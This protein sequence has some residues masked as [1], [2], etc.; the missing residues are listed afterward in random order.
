[1]LHHSS[2]CWDG[3][4]GTRP[5]DGAVLHHIDSSAPPKI[6]YHGKSSS[7]RATLC[8]FS[9]WRAAQR[10]LEKTLFSSQRFFFSFF[11]ICEGW[12]CSLLPFD[13]PQS[14]GNTRGRPLRSD[15]QGSVSVSAARSL[16]MLCIIAQGHRRV[17][18]HVNCWFICVF[19]EVHM[20]KISCENMNFSC[21]FHL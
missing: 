10:K 16:L 2:Y 8:D 21:G 15:Q 6:T 20:W 9:S 3:L 11:L 13:L 12:L 19:R 14:V 5:L 7:C 17:Y 4:C 1:M 18:P